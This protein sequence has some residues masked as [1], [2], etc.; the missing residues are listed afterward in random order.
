MS[1]CPLGN[2][3]LSKFGLSR[4]LWAQLALPAQFLYLQMGYDHSSSLL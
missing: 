2:L 1:P 3:A 4:W